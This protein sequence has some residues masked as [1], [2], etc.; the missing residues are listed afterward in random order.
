MRDPL[1]LFSRYCVCTNDTRC[2][3]RWNLDSDCYDYK[4]DTPKTW[5]C[6]YFIKSW[7][8]P[9]LGKCFVVAR[10]M[11]RLHWRHCWNGT[12]KPAV[13]RTTIFL[14]STQRDIF[15]YLTFVAFSGPTRYH[16]RQ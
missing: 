13:K 15:I 3:R 11:F 6:C 4:I 10:R 12:K 2:N 16:R 1:Y 14:W 9:F 8:E 7:S 5:R